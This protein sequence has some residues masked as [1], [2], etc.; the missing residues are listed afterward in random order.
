MGTSGGENVIVG[1][2]RV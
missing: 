1:R 2:K